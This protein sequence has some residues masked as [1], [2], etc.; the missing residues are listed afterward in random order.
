MVTEKKKVS[1]AYK[2]HS[3]DELTRVAKIGTGIEH[4]YRHTIETKGGIVL[5]VDIEPEDFTA[6]KVAP[7]LLAKAQEADKILQLEG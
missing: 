7:I 2:V 6:D 1:K 3:I 4:F 5:T